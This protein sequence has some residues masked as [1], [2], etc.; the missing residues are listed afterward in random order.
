MHASD[1]MT[2]CWRL[3]LNLLSTRSWSFFARSPGYIW[4]YL[5]WKRNLPQCLQRSVTSLYVSTLLPE[6]SLFCA[7]V[8]ARVQ[9]IFKMASFLRGQLSCLCRIKTVHINSYP[10]ICRYSDN[11][12]DRP[13]MGPPIPPYQRRQGEI[14]DVKKA[15]LLHQSRCVCLQIYM[16]LLLSTP[17]DLLRPVVQSWISANLGFKF[18]PVF[19]YFCMIVYFKTS[20]K[21]T[22]IDPA[23]I[24]EE[25][26]LNSV[27]SRNVP[28]L[29][30]PRLYTVKT[31]PGQKTL[32]LVFK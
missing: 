21:K 12:I 32:T 25:I 6:W 10:A 4:V 24:S 22:S 11:I 31:S 15:R 27:S 30:R 28:R 20:E 18:N 13:D 14:I 5:I 9:V 23:K 7:R 29:K 2:T 17:P 26:F 19:V 16:G 8:T 1:W 3:T